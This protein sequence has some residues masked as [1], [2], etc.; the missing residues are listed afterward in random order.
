MERKPAVI[1]QAIALIVLLTVINI[2]LFLLLAYGHDATIS[3]TIRW[4]SRSFPLLPYLV[5]FMMGAMFWHW[6]LCQ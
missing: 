6:F 5:S 4:W 2:D 3:A 1:F